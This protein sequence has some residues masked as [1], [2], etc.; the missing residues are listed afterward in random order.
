MHKTVGKEEQR[1]ESKDYRRM[2]KEEERN[3]IR[4]QTWWELQKSP[5]Q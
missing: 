1:H 4:Q 5:T 2:K 3:F